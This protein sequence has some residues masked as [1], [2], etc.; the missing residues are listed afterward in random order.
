MKRLLTHRQQQFLSDFLDLFRE[1]DQPV[2]YSQ[3]AKRLDV[4]KVTAY[5]MLRLLEERGLVRAEY[6]PNPVQSG[7]GRSMVLFSPTQ[8]GRQ[9]IAMLAGDSGDLE[10]WQA[11]RE[12]LLQQVR[13]GKV[14]GYDSL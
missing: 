1:L 7:P 13:E 3:V 14:G 11:A 9:V 5:E 4:G 2:H 6:Q 10:D 8:A 12:R